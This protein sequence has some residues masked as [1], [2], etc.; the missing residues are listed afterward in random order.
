MAALKTF[1][2]SGYVLEPAGA[3]H[4][5]LAQTWT[6]WDKYHAGIIPPEFWLYQ[7]P[8]TDSYILRDGAGWVFFLKVHADELKKDGWPRRVKLHIQ[9]MPVVTEDDRERTME[10]LLQ[11]SRWLEELL[12]RNGAEEIYFDSQSRPLISFAVKRMGFR[13]A[14]DAG[15]D[16]E[17]R[18][19]KRLLPEG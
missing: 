10:G 6:A 1:T 9:F 17:Y 8:R 4:L 7:G 13:V 3:E 18:L 11:G 16:G 2:F 5:K 12:L 14:F 19:T 15:S